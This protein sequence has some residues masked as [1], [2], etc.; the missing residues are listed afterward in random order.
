MTVYVGSRYMCS[1]VKAMVVLVHH[2][3]YIDMTMMGLECDVNTASASLPSPL[4]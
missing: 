4:R 1:V 2:I 3:D